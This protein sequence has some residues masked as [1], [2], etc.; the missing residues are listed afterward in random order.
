MDRI[1]AYTKLNKDNTA[2]SL[3]TLHLLSNIDNK[4]TLKEITNFFNSHTLKTSPIKIKEKETLSLIEIFRTNDFLRDKLNLKKHVTDL[5]TLMSTEI[6]FLNFDEIENFVVNHKEE[7]AFYLHTQGILN[8]TMCVC[9]ILLTQLNYQ[10][11]FNTPKNSS[12]NVSESIFDYFCDEC[13]IK[14]AKTNEKFRKFYFFYCKNNRKMQFINFVKDEF[15]DYKYFLNFEDYFLFLKSKVITEE[16]VKNIISFYY[17]NFNLEDECSFINDTFFLSDEENFC[18]IEVKKIEP[19]KNIEKNRKID[20][21]DFL[22]ENK[23]DF[24]LLNDKEFLFRY[25]DNPYFINKYIKEYIINNIEIKEMNDY[26]LI[27]NEILKN[28]LNGVKIPIIKNYDW[29]NENEKEILI[30][31]YLQKYSPD[32]IFDLVYSINKNLKLNFKNAYFD[33]LYNCKFNNEISEEVF[34]K[35]SEKSVI[36]LIKECICADQLIKHLNLNKLSESVLVIL[37]KKVTNPLDLIKNL[38]DKKV[39]IGFFDE[40]TL[41]DPSFT[42]PLIIKILENNLNLKLCKSVFN[43]L[44]NVVLVDDFFEEKN[45]D[46]IKYIIEITIPIEDAQLERM[47]NECIQLLSRYAQ[48]YQKRL[49]VR[50]VKEI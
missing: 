2:Y 44:N 34:K 46:L 37:V 40:L 32:E 23:K 42:L 29:L 11:K 18:E 16:D 27:Y 3:D 20:L 4:F 8:D 50:N 12:F 17:D 22:V 9:A 24:S 10:N 43:Y 13:F 49:R 33:L 41:Y 26:F 36:R 28:E 47:K 21:I 19:I 39:K 6:S 25:K 14:F 48:C 45:L 5:F 38:I 35:L 1:Y 15:V 30:N 31:L 7:V